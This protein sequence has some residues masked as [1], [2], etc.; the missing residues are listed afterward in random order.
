MGGVDKKWCDKR[1]AVA[2]ST[3]AAV[4]DSPPQASSSAS[5]SANDVSSMSTETTDPSS[6]PTVTSETD[7]SLDSHTS[8]GALACCR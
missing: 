8:L 6:D 5:S 4:I 3:G 7:S 2:F 1:P